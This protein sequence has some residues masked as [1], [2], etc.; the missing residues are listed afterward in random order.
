MNIADAD[1]LMLNQEWRLNNLYKISDA[2]GKCIDFKLNWAQ[3]NFLSEMHYFNV[4]LKARQLGFSTFIL[5]YML[6]CALFNSNHSCGVIAQGL[7]EAADLFDN[8]VKFAYEHLPEEIKRLRPLVADSARELEFNNGSSIVVGTSLRGGTYQKLHVSEYGKIAA[9]YPEKA[10]EIKTGAFNT[11]HAGQQLFVESTAEGMQ[12]EFFE[13]V[14]LARRLEDEG[15]KLSPLDPMF[16][17]YPWYQNPAYQ[18]D[19]ID[20]RMVTITRQDADY[21]DSLDVKLTHGQKCWYIKKAQVMGDDMKREFPTSPDEAFSASLEGAYYAKQMRRVRQNGQITRVQHEPKALVYTFWDIGNW[22]HMPIWFMQHVGREYRFIDYL[23]DPNADL[24]FIAKYFRDSG[25]SFGGHYLPHDGTTARLG[26][27][28]NQS[29]KEMLESLGVRNIHI[30]PRTND[31]R[32][33]IETKCKPIL[34][35]CWFDETKCA[36][37]ILALD[38][39]RKVWDVRLEVWKEE[40]RGDEFSHGADAYRTFAVGYQ[41]I[42]EEFYTDDWHDDEPDDYEP[43]SKAKNRLS[44]Y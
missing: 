37:G 19:G 29:V 33:D 28:K 18:L 41:P 10:K 16:H 25:Y 24:P 42:R 8:K 36:T 14:K 11:V 35:R 13:L 17:F 31:I 3:K 4:I 39:Y 22:D 2:A 32:R 7:T 43:E 27:Q 5:I 23:Q 40:P 9:R 38:S 44:G 12:G 26:L 6:D 20:A 34:E 15:R 1:A 21:F 30:V